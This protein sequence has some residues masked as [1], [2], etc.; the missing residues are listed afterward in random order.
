VRVLA[1]GGAGVIGSE[2][3]RMLLGHGSGSD[4]PA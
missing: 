1:T 3:V 2:Y 4:L